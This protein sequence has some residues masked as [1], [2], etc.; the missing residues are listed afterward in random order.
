MTPQWLQNGCPKDFKLLK[1]NHIIYSFEVLS[2]NVSIS[3]FYEHFKKFRKNCFACIFS[4]FK[5]FARQFTSME[6][7]DHVL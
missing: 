4:K 1:Y 2:R 7:P 3:R 6:S 5:Y